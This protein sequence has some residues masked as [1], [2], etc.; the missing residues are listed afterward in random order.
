ME[1]VEATK[2]AFYKQGVAKT[3][4]WLVEELAEVC[5]DYCKEIWGKA[6]D[7]A[8]VSASSEWRQ[9]GKI[10][11]H[12]DIHEILGA[13]TINPESFEQ[14]LIMQGLLP[15]EAPKEPKDATKPKDSITSKDATKAKD[16]TK[17]EGEAKAKYD[18][19][20]KADAKAKDAAKVKEVDTQ[21]KK[22]GPLVK[23]TTA[24]QPNK[25][26]DLPRLSKEDPAPAS[27]V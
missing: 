13:P 20:A 1:V 14:S 9:P 10:Y 25:K 27:K 22:I 5:K 3:E 8:R 26:D 18:A 7:L 21:S 2:Q 12:P 16:D 19:K 11:Y 24:S 4:I 6:L 15:L 23:D 17:A